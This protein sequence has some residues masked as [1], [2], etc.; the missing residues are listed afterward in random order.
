[1]NGDVINEPMGSVGGFLG[2]MVSGVVIMILVFFFTSMGTSLTEVSPAKYRLADVLV[3]DFPDDLAV[4]YGDLM[5]NDDILT[6]SEYDWLVS[7][8]E[9][10]TRAKTARERVQ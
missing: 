10:L 8:W 2:G 9:R 5:L 4:G 7:E 6:N 1:M 3:N